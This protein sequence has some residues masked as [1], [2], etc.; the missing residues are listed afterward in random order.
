MGDVFAKRCVW[1]LLRCLRVVVIR[2]DLAWSRQVG[3]RLRLALGIHS[4]AP[5]T[6]A[7]WMVRAAAVIVGR[8][9]GAALGYFL[10]PMVTVALGVFVLRERLRPLQW[11]TRI[12]AA[13]WLCLRLAGGGSR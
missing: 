5:T 12:G 11:V 9:T 8:T 4:P 3:T 10:D 6:G 7:D 2:R 13:A 1:N